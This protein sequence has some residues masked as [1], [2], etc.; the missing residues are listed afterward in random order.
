MFTE[1][2]RKK[3]SENAFLLFLPTAINADCRTFWKEVSAENRNCLTTKHWAAQW[4]P[5]RKEGCPIKPTNPASGAGPAPE[6]RWTVAA[7]DR[8]AA[9]KITW[10]AGAGQRIHPIPLS[11]VPGLTAYEDTAFY[12]E[13]SG[14]VTVYGRVGPTG[15]T[16]TETT[17]LAELPREYCPRT[18]LTRVAVLTG[19]PGYTGPRTA[20]L[21]VSTTGLI[22]LWHS[23]RGAASAAAFEFSYLLPE[24]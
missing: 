22:Y 21:Q 2:G 10:P 5:A 3:N 12:C 18:S 9:R 19:P 15:G 11:L 14:R 20:V 6:S 24:R 8:E 23:G 17:A 4:Q 13:S 1:G 16:F 7:T